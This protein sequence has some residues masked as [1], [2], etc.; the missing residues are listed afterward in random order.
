MSSP[1]ERVREHV[2][3]CVDEILENYDLD[4]DDSLHDAV[5]EQ[6]D[7]SFGELVQHGMI[8]DYN[9][10]DMVRTASDCAAIIEVAED[11]R[12]VADDSGLWEG[13]RYGVLAAIAF[14][15]L[16][17]LIRDALDERRASA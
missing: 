17:N 10:Q 13:L 12:C 4:D 3:M 14:H 6:C 16:E 15:S 8:S 9:V 1:Q 11:E 5:F 2:T 7:S